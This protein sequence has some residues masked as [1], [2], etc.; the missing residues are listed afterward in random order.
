VPGLSCIG[1]VTTLGEVV[2]DLLDG[3]GDSGFG[4]DLPTAEGDRGGA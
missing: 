1:L 4:G 2:E 3:G